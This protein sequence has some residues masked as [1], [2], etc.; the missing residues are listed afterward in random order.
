MGLTGT[1]VALAVNLAALLVFGKPSAAFFSE[2]WWSILLPQ[3]LV[4]LV[5]III[6]IGTKLWG[7][8]GRDGTGPT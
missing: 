7:K 6:G 5:F 8:E 2:D 1:V 3:Y 4:W